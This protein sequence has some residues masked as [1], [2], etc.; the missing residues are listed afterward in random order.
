MLNL[1]K[2]DVRLAV[3]SACETGIPGEELPDEVVSLPSG[4][5]QA[6]VAGIVASLWSVDD[7]AT[8]MLL[9]RFY[10]LWRGKEKL[11]PHEALRQAQQW[12]RDTTNGD[13]KKY[14]KQLKDN[15]SNEVILPSTARFLWG[16]LVD[17][18][19]FRDEKGLGF[20]DPYYWAAFNYVGV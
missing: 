4:L 12:V 15:Q 18:H 13:K 11:E 2:R 5:L 3:L 10:E 6:G 19:R 8:A 1:R 7:L 17:N 14:F 16:K 20:A 9:V